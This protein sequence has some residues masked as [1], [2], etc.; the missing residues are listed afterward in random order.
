MKALDETF[1]LVIAYE[2]STGKECNLVI[3]EDTPITNHMNW[4]LFLPR[5]VITHLFVVA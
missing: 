5:F 3:C 2:G 1:S 4:K